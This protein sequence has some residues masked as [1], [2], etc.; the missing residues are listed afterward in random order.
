MPGTFP[1]VWLSALPCFVVTLQGCQPRTGD[2]A[3]TAPARTGAADPRVVAPGTG[4]RLAIDSVTGQPGAGTVSL[5]N[6]TPDNLRIWR[7][8]TSWGDVVLSFRGR[9]GDVDVTVV[10]RIEVYT[11]NGPIPVDVP[12]QGRYQWRFDFGDG[13]WEPSVPFDRWVWPEVELT[14]VYEVVAD[15]EARQ[16]GVWQG[17]LESKPF[18]WPTRK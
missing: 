17:R 7:E 8:D 12:P 6:E 11:K 9:S 18:A 13:H 14:A 5:S 16:L 4:L 15:P 3:G 10:R 2:P 1:A